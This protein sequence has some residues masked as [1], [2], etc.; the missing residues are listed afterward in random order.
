M[1]LEAAAAAAAVAP[2]NNAG[3][4]ADQEVSL[5]G[6]ILLLSLSPRRRAT[7]HLSSI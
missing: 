6:V 5:R 1:M 2:L 7:M 3:G 4:R